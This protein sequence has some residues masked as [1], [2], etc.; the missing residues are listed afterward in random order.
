MRFQF[1]LH[2]QP[3]IIPMLHIRSATLADELNL[4]NVNFF[5]YSRNVKSLRYLPELAIGYAL[6][7]GVGGVKDLDLSLGGSLFSRFGPG[8]RVVFEGYAFG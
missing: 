8:T 3:R 4:S 2:M 6:V 1:R 5:V 7:D